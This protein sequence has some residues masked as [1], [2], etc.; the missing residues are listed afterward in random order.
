MGCWDEF[1]VICGGPPYAPDDDECRSFTEQGESKELLHFHD[2]EWLD[3]LVGITEAEELIP[4]GGYIDNGS[5][6]LPNN[7]EFKGFKHPP[8][9]PPCPR[10]IFCHERC[11]RLLQRDLGYTLRFQDVEPLLRESGDDFWISHLEGY[12]DYGGMEAYHEQYFSFYRAFADGKECMLRD[13][14]ECRENAERI[15]GV[16]R[17]FL[18]SEFKVE[19]RSRG[20]GGG[21]VEGSDEVDVEGSDEVH[22]EGSAEMDVEGSDAV[23]VDGVSGE[24]RADSGVVAAVS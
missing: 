12:T 23:H 17:P 18:E 2:F 20:D 8:S 1:C 24:R 16:W 22:D 10:G 21:H 11:L 15:L 9:T 6:S 4:L 5:F 3:K 7:S 19:R 14:M 13:P